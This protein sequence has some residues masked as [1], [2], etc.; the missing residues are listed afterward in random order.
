MVKIILIFVMKMVFIIKMKLIYKQTYHMI[1][2]LIMIVRTTIYL[3]LLLLTIIM[4]MLI[5][6]LFRTIAY[7]ELLIILIKFFFSGPLH[8][9]RCLLIDHISSF[10]DHYMEVLLGKNKATVDIEQCTVVG[11]I[12]S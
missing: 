3:E 4:V 7:M 10:Q 6:T 2:L 1:S 11:Y 8:A 5:M 9:R 12:F